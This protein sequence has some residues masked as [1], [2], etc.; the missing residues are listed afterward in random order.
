MKISYNAS[1]TRHA[2]DLATHSPLLKFHVTQALVLKV[3]ASIFLSVAG[4]YYLAAGRRRQSLNTMLM[5]GALL[6]LA[7]FLF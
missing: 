7:L 4:M 1:A 6:L 5:G 2:M 3:L